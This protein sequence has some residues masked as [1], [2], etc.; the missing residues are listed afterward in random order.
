MNATLRELVALL[1]RAKEDLEKG[2]PEAA[3][4]ALG[5]A[6][7]VAREAQEATPHG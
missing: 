7:R 1:E 5:R 6:I 3:L 4:D 2:W